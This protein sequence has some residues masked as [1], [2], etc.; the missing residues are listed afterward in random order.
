MKCRAYAS[1]DNDEMIDFD[2]PTEHL[3]SMKTLQAM[4][5]DIPDTD[6]AIDFTVSDIK[7]TKESMEYVI[8]FCDLY[9]DDMEFIPERDREL[10]DADRDYFNNLSKEMLEKVTCISDHLDIKKLLEKATQHYAEIFKGKSVKELQE[11]FGE[12]NGFTPQ[13]EE[14]I[15]KQFEWCVEKP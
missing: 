11:Y 12:K 14:E 1:E 13:E 4:I 3:K 2:I 9:K 5:E 15:K 8:K 10:N 7:I 6:E